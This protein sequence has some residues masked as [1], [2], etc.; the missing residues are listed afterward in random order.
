[1]AEPAVIEPPRTS[2]PPSS[3]GIG[4]WLILMAIGQVLGP[5]RTLV[6][7]GTTY[8]SQDVQ[9]ALNK[10]PVTMYGTLSIDILSFLFVVATAIAF[11]AQKRIF[12]TMFT[13]EVFGVLLV[14]PITYAWVSATSGIPV[15][16]LLS[17][18]DL[19]KAI[20]AFLVG[21]IWVA[22]VWR[23]KRVRNTFIR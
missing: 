21:L 20:G 7:L 6:S 5:L 17:A 13:I 15:N 10:L 4:G 18:D 22:Y 23:S 9:L 3:S 19:G 14:Y 11:F 12:K 16:Q 2:I 1:M 8:S